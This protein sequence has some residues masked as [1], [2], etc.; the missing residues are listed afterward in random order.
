MN[1]NQTH[2][3]LMTSTEI[4]TVLEGAIDDSVLRDW[5]PTVDLRHIDREA[6][7]AEL[8]A[9]DGYEDSDTATSEAEDREPD[10]PDA[11]DAWGTRE[12][13]QAWRICVRLAE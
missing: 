1:S 12:D 11:L 13:G 7:E 10:E 2:D 9:L 8:C 5:C 3:A 4:R 6:V